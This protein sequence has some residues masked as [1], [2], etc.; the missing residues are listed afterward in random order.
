MKKIIS[1]LDAYK[2]LIIMVNSIAVI[3]SSCINPLLGK[4]QGL[5]FTV[6]VLGAFQIASKAVKM[7]SF[8]FKDIP[9]KISYRIHIIAEVMI[10]I[11]VVIFFWSPLYSLI[12][13]FTVNTLMELLSSNIS[14]ALEKWGNDSYGTDN[15]KDYK[16]FKKLI[17]SF[18]GI[19][20]NVCLIVIVELFG[21]TPILVI[22]A[23]S[24][25]IQ[26]ILQTKMYRQYIVHIE[27]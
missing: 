17:V 5:V 14:F 1:Q 8:L 9:L 23:L 24:K 10:G 20:G 15:W 19:L 3:A 16:H 2:Y 7:V 26:F 22:V 13:I 4:T 11:G 21:N 18:I 27:R 6:A 25:T 12:I